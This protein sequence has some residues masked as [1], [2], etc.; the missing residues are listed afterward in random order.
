METLAGL[1]FDQDQK[2]TGEKMKKNIKILSL[3]ILGLLMFVGCTTSQSTPSNK[4]DIIYYLN[5]EKIVLEPNTYTKGEGVT[6]AIP[7]LE[8][9]E[10]FSGWYDNSECI[11]I[12][13]SNINIKKN[14][15]V[16]GKWDFEPYTYTLNYETERSAAL[17]KI[18]VTSGYN[19][20]GYRIVK[21]SGY[22]SGDDAIQI[23]RGTAS[24]WDGSGATN[25]GEK[26]MQSLTVIR[27]NA[28]KELKEAAYDLGCNAIIG[29]DF[30]YLT[31]DPQ[32]ATSTG[33][34]MYQP[35]VFGVTANGTAVKIEKIED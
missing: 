34:T 2:K 4:Y 11:G 6:L 9:D 21:Y 5:D 27:R 7:S 19:F 18:L 23:D 13:I 22:I 10:T 25:V 12:P 1:F 28:L 30:D 32:T 35:Y 33:G 29:V 26:L 3:I 16:Y 17:P 14:E 8:D 15:T 24:F 31:L 20:E